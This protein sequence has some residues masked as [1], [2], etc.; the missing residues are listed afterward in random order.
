VCGLRMLAVKKSMWRQVAWS[1]A[2]AIS[3]GM[4]CAFGSGGQHDGLDGIDDRG[5]LIGHETV[6]NL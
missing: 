2:S 1:P 4:G 3:A 5:E 6:Q